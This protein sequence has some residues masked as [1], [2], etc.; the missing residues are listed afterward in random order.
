V[1]HKVFKKLLKFEKKLGLE[2]K[3]HGVGEKD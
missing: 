2:V 3:R 1:S